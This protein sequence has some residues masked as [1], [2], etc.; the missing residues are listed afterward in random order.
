M[1]VIVLEC[2]VWN[3]LLRLIRQF[4]LVHTFAKDPPV[5]DDGSEGNGGHCLMMFDVCVSM[6]A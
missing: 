6:E 4:D 1:T 5:A 2:L 3:K